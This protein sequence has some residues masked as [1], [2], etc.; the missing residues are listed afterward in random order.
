MRVIIPKKRAGAR[1]GQAWPGWARHG[2]A[3]QGKAWRG[4]AWIKDRL[5]DE[6]RPDQH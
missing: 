2:Q 3:R 4:K 1:L 6:C 5:A